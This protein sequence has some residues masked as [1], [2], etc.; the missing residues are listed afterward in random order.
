VCTVQMC[1]LMH[2]SGV[3]SL[4][5]SASALLILSFSLPLLAQYNSAVG[6]SVVTDVD[7]DMLFVPARPLEM[8]IYVVCSAV[9]VLWGH[10]HISFNVFTYLMQREPKMIQLVAG[11]MAL[12]FGYIMVLLVTLQDQHTRIRR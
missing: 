1:K 3:N 11:S 5:M 2:L 10:R 8:T 6:D 12:Y 4:Q 7:L 9:A